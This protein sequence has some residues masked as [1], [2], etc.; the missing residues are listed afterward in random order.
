[1]DKFR[2]SRIIRCKFL[3]AGMEVAI[4]W[5]VVHMQLLE[6]EGKRKKSSTEHK[7][8]KKHKRSREYSE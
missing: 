1:M 4:K 3:T 2:A 5:C 7:K 6:S 8:K